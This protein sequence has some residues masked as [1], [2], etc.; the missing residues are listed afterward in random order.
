MTF[1]TRKKKIIIY[2]YYNN[3]LLD[4]ELKTGNHYKKENGNSNISMRKYNKPMND[5]FVVITLWE[6]IAKKNLKVQQSKTF[7]LGFFLKPKRKERN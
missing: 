5:L 1:V 7:S 2:I 4:C 3:F 6:W